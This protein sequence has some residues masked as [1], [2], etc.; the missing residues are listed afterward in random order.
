[1]RYAQ[2]IPTKTR[3]PLAVG[4][5]TA[6]RDASSNVVLR[7]NSVQQRPKYRYSLTEQFPE[8]LETDFNTSSHS[9]GERNHG[10]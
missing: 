9:G 3:L 6:R 10:R 2:R 4:S 5:T 7:E 8:T 1:M